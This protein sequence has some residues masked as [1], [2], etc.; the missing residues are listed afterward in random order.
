MFCIPLTSINGLHP[1]VVR[2][3]EDAKITVD[4]YRRS[5]LKANKTETRES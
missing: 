2:M 1:Y 5:I 3:R 4:Y